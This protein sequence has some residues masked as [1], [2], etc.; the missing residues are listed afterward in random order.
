[1]AHR[2][3][4]A[5]L[6]LRPL[7]A[8][9]LDTLVMAINNYAIA[10][11]LARVPFPYHQSDAES[12]F[13]FASGLGQRSFVAA[14]C[15]HASPQ[16]MVGII[17]YEFSAETNDAEMGYWLAEAHW[18]KGIMKEAARAMVDHA[19]DV[20]GHEILVSAYHDDNPVSGKVLRRVGFI[21]A[22]STRHFAKA[23]ALEVSVTLMRLTRAR[24]E[25][26][27]IEG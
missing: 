9:D 13:E 7:L 23:Q 16:E 17:S 21:N 18:G 20:A 14:I 19:F 24:W 5:R 25:E 1:M 12:F 15:F 6:L 11:N 27:R 3:E 8:E 4:T 10:K 2:I 26:L 22:G